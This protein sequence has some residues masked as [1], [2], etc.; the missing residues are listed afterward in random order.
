MPNDVIKLPSIVN[1]A[2]TYKSAVLNISLRTT[3]TPS[4]RK[5]GT[6]IPD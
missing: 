1:V 3:S 4:I 5:Y 2:R 6:S